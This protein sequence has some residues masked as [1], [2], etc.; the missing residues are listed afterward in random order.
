MHCI[1]SDL[2]QIVDLSQEIE[3]Y[4]NSLNLQELIL[5]DSNEPSTLVGNKLICNERSYSE[6]IQKVSF[7]KGVSEMKKLVREVQ[8]EKNIN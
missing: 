2:R 3:D 4:F 8:Y 5:V 1:L 6:N 7:I